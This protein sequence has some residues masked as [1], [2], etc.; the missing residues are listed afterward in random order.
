MKN[1]KYLNY[2]SDKTKNEPFIDRLKIKFR[3]LIFPMD[4]LLDQVN[5]TDTIFDIGCG[6]GQFSLLAVHFKKVNKV[7]GVEIHKNLVDNA[8]N[9]FNKNT[10]RI[11]FSFMQYDGN[12]FP[13]QIKTCSKV[14]LND[15]LH[16]IPKEN[17]INFL[18]NIYISLSTDTVFILKDI[19][20]SSMFVYFN[21]LHDF[22]FA[23]EVGNEFK[24]E[25]I[26]NVLRQIGFKIL[27]TKREN[28]AVYPHY[29]IICKK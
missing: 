1:N 15:V 6:S 8:T 5:E 18:K 16:H 10:K 28:I 23:G 24:F 9:L 7:Y 14:F 13:Y 11:N 2:L 3:P 29:T 4:F 26:Q 21:K 17:Q 22:I 25:K 12:K 27:K 19:D 20:A